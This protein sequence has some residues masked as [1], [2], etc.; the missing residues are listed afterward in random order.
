MEEYIINDPGMSDTLRWMA[1]NIT[2]EAIPE[3]STGIWR[4]I[5]PIILFSYDIY[6]QYWM[7]HPFV[8]YM[9]VGFSLGLYTR[10]S[11]L[12]GYL[13]LKTYLGICT[14]IIFIP[15]IEVLLRIAMAIE[16]KTI[17]KANKNYYDE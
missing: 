4:V 16:N 10:N 14:F 12:K 5:D 7:L 11:A 8:Q 9:I 6:E 13:G 15:F 17:D 2:G 3:P 1:D